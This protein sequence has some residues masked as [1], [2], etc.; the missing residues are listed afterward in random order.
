ME[1]PSA[2]RDHIDRVI[3]EWAHARPDLDMTPLEIL[4][5][6]ARIAGLFR[7]A[8][9]RMVAQYG[10]DVNEWALL[11][12]LYRTQRAEGITPTA[13]ARS[14]LVTSGGV[15]RLIVRLRTR[16]L[17]RR[18]QDPRDKR[19]A[20]LELT[21]RGLKIVETAFTAQNQ[22]EHGLVAALPEPERAHL[23]AL[24]RK[25][26]LSIDEAPA[27]LPKRHKPAA[28]PR[29]SARRAARAPIDGVDDRGPET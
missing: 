10:I 8:G 29:R 18:H 12:A 6:I 27:A 28:A 3:E 1:T 22:L 5:R 4:G 19:R 15:T 16:G 11:T 14:L 25:L 20:V 17:I 24:L 26:L 21:P 9:R 7:A 13:L 2:A 23:I